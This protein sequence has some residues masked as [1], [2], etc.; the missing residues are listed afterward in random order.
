MH[1]FCRNVIQEHHKV[2]VSCH[3]SQFANTEIVDKKPK[4]CIFTTKNMKSYGPNNPHCLLVGGFQ[5]YQLFATFSHSYY[6]REMAILVNY[7]NV[8]GFELII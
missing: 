7:K 3:Q 6:L 5:F 8:L 1:L 2:P 4:R